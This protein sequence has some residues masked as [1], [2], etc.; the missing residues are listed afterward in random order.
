LDGFELLSELSAGVKTAPPQVIFTTAY[1]K[2]ALQAFE[3]HAV[4]YLLKPFS[5]ERLVSAIDQVRRNLAPL[6]ANHSRTAAP[7]GKAY[8]T[9]IVFKSRGRIVF[10]P[11]DSIQWIAAE[12][13]YVRLCLK[14]ESHLLR[15]TMTKLEDRLDPE[16]FMRVHRGAIVNLHYLKEVRTEADGEYVVILVD[17]QKVG[18]SR[19]YRGRING[20]LARK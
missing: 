12:Q 4:D 19:T 15:E 18:M 10:L 13:N 8:T 14:D 17:G 16:M 11:V 2:Y 6:E 3:V 9:R 20:W 7:A 1:D 5:Q